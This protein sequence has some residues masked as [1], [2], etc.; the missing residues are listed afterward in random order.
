MYVYISF[1]SFLPRLLLTKLSY[2]VS[3]E[4]RVVKDGQYG[5]EDSA[6]VGGWDGMVG[7]LV[8]RV[9]L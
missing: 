7:E 2:V 9:C 1:L 6:H 4:L 8:R 5:T 3:D